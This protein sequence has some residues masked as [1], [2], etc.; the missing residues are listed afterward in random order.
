LSEKKNKK[1][2]NAQK[3]KK[4]HRSIT[5]HHPGKDNAGIQIKAHEQTEVSTGDNISFKAGNHS[6][7]QVKL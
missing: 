7:M 4:N 2:E 6:F 5:Y 1:G 3:V